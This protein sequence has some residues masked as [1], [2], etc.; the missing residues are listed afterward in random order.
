MPAAFLLTILRVSVRITTN[1]ATTERR[2]WNN[3][4]YHIYIKI[5]QQVK[6]KTSVQYIFFQEVK[7]YR[8]Q[9]VLKLMLS[10][11]HSKSLKIEILHF[12]QYFYL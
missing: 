10:F 1:V 11:A 4:L 2:K 12:Y 3:M 9:I 5:H 6:K 8:Y 7:Q